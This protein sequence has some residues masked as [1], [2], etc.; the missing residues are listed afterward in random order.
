MT[1]TR[2]D[3][4]DLLS[5]DEVDYQRAAALGPEALTHLDDLIDSEDELLASKAAYLTGLIDGEEREQI[6][7]RASRSPEPT[8]RL[9][10]T[11]GLSSLP[12]DVA[13]PLL[14]QLLTD[15][16]PGVRKQAILSASEGV[17][18]EQISGQL[19]DIAEH[20]SSPRLRDVAREVLEHPD[21]PHTGEMG[22]D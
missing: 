22:A 12:M 20:D 9:A 3:V 15:E 14:H 8:V 6:L 7:R 17:V 2:Q 21:H 4:L 5:A 18:S 1:V 16:D 11:A 10:A 13:E 19:R